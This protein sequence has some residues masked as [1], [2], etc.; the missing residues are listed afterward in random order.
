[1]KRRDYSG[2]IETVDVLLNYL[3][4]DLKDTF[5]QEEFSVCFPK[6]Y[7]NHPDVLKLYKKYLC[8]RN[9]IHIRVEK[10][11]TTAYP[12]R[13]GANDDLLEMSDKKLQKEEDSLRAQLQALEAETA[14][15]KTQ[16]KQFERDLKEILA[17]N[18]KKP[19]RK[20]NSLKNIEKL[21]TLLET[22]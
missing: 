9:E 18:L 22:D 1:M 15:Y 3:R 17:Q 13:A 7:R 20:L 12:I 4:A 5:T 19:K 2:N 11:I 6:E 16:L 14:E 8:Q 10:N 21:T